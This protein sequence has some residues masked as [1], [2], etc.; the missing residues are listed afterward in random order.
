MVGGGVGIDHK[1]A[2]FE[3]LVVVL[4]GNAVLDNRRVEFAA[5]RALD[6]DSLDFEAVGVEQVSEIALFCGRVLASKQTVIEACF[7]IDT[8][9]ALHPVDSRFGLTVAAF[10]TRLRVGIVG[11]I[12]GG[13]IALG[14]FLTACGLDDIRRFEPHLPSA[15]AET[16]E[17]LVRLLEEIA[18]LNI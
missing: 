16:E 12:D 4:L 11:G 5:E 7:G 10:G 6:L 14:V 3:Q 18:T 8:R 17:V 2:L 9:I 15:G 13:D 1:I